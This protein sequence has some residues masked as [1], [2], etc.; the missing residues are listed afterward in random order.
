[1]PNSSRSS[2]RLPPCRLEWSPAPAVAAGVLLASLLA[3]AGLCLT[4]LPDGVRFA[5]QLACA[6]YGLWQARQWL[7]SPVQ[8]LV[9]DRHGGQVWVDGH[10]VEAF[11]P[12]WRCGLLQLRWRLAGRWQRRVCL[13]WQ[14]APG[15]VSELR[16]WPQQAKHSRNDAPVAP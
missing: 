13:P 8:A 2:A 5:A 1:M 4:A 14:L 7:S 9:L 16:Q 6:V 3:I 15:V 10:A 11:Q 12:G